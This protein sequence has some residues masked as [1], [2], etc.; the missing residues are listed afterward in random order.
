MSKGV[1]AGVIGLMLSMVGLDPTTSTQRYTFGML[2]LKLQVS[3]YLWKFVPTADPSFGAFPDPLD[4]R[5]GSH[6]CHM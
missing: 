6:A 3:G 1:L 4:G 2:E 5:F